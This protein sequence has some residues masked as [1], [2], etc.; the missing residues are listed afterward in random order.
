MNVPFSESTLAS[1]LSAIS[2][3]FVPFRLET[4][5]VVAGS[6][7]SDGIPDVDSLLFAGNFAVHHI[8]GRLLGPSI[9]VATSRRKT[10]R[11][12]TTPTTTLLTSSADLRKS[13]VS[14]IASLFCSKAPPTAAAG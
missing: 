2:I 4:A 14:T 6:M 13:P 10:G 12:P 8:I 5:I 11:S 7:A 9:I 3:A 1:T